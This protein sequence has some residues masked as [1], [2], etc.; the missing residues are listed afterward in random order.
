M[1]FTIRYYLANKERPERVTI[2]SRNIDATDKDDALKSADSWEKLDYPH[3]DK[4]NLLAT[5]AEEVPMPAIS[6]R[7]PLTKGEARIGFATTDPANEDEENIKGVAA[8]FI[9]YVEAIALRSDDNEV[10][11]L[12]SLAQ[13]EMENAAMW[14]VKA[15]TKPK[16]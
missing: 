5:T 11:R 1:L 6:R 2:V 4:V 7:R 12:A 3:K 8:Q 14:A 13:T 15:A 16:Q 10:K 9:D